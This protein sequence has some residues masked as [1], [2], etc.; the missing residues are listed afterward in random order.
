MRLWGI[1]ELDPILGKC[2]SP[3]LGTPSNLKA[4]DSIRLHKKL[5]VLIIT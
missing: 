5:H 1:G 2:E 4:L 3:M